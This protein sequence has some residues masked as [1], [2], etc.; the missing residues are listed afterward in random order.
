M[1]ESPVPP[2]FNA[3]LVR[4]FR[5]N[6]GRG[7]GVFADAPL[8]LLHHVGARTGAERVAPLIYLAEGDRLFVFASKGGEDDNPAWYHNLKANPRTK[9]ELGGETFEVVATEL[10][11]A[12]R[13]EYYAKQAAAMPQFGDYERKTSRVIP[14]IELKRG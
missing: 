5:Q 11:G 7:I 8:I 1:S 6:G 14:V 4:A 9:A 12:E 10:T 13:D 3:E 2:D